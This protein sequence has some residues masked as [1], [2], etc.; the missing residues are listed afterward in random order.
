MA[1][2]QDGERGDTRKAFAAVAD[3][4]AEWREEFSEAAERHSHAVAEKL[5][6]AA[7]SVG[8]PNEVVEASQTHLTQMGRMQLQMMDQV[9]EAW[10]QQL[11]S[12]AAAEFMSALRSAG[13]ASALAPTMRTPWQLWLDATLAWQRNLASAWSTWGRGGGS[14][15]H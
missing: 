2:T 9:I 12:P 13:G 1:R 11:K 8:W 5:G 6:D 3:A 7:R 15:H 14:R 4:L 10:Q